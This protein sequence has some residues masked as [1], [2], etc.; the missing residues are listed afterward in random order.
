MMTNAYISTRKISPDPKPRWAWRIEC[1]EGFYDWQGPFRTQ[2]AALKAG[3]AALMR[4]EARLN[5]TR[6]AQ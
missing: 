6:R 4:I 1:V 2:T 5:P 3:Y